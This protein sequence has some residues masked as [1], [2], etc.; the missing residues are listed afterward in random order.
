[1]P[2][3]QWS[4]SKLHCYESCPRKFKEKY[5]NKI[6]DKPGPAAQRGN[7]IHAKAE[8][9]LGGKIRGLPRE[10]ERLGSQYRKLKK[11]K[12][13]VEIKLAVDVDWN[14]VGWREG[15][16]RGIVDALTRVDDEMI[17]IDHKTGG[18]Y[19]KHEEQ[20]KLYACLTGATDSECESFHVEFWYID[21]GYTEVWDYNHVELIDIRGEFEDRANKMLSAK[22]FP[23]TPSLDA[24][25]WCPAASKKGGPCHGWKKV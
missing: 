14:P 16:A 20:A 13:L 3:E 10:L 8:N 5:F 2:I 22:R 9:Y 15:W 18:I 24:C 25:R 17:I 23:Q 7:E 11:T 4:I 1:M 19:E 12:P 6:P 21:K